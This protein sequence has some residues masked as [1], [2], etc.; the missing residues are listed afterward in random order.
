M[1]VI[2]PL[3]LVVILLA[4]AASLYPEGLWGNAINL[5][6]IILAGLL[7]FNF[8]EPL[9]RF[10]EGQMASYT[11][12]LDFISLWLIFCVSL[13]VL[14]TASN[15]LSRVK[16]RFLMIVDRVGSGILAVLVGWV[17]VCFTAATLHTAPL[18]RNFMWGGFNPEK[19]MLFGLAPDRQWLGLVRL[20]SRGGLSGGNQFDTRFIVQYA[21]FRS[22][23][24]KASESGSLRVASSPI[25]PRAGGEA[26]RQEEP[27][28]SGE[29]AAMPAGDV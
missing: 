4:C 29:E 3:L 26:S 11:F 17:M 28:S 2:F 16:V 10:L 5:V 20:A 22:A 24:E 7:A 25:P 14:R 15:L 6:N 18:A 1:T 13:V 19:R 23:V 8:F 9:A 12:F 27:A 21:D